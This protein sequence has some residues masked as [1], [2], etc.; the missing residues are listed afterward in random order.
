MRYNDP[1]MQECT[2]EIITEAAKKANLDNHIMSCSE[3]PAF[4]LS[5]K[6][7]GNSFMASSW[8]LYPTQHNWH[9]NIM[10]YKELTSRYLNHGDFKSIPGMYINTENMSSQELLDSL[11]EYV[12]EIGFPC[13]I[14]PN[15]G[16]GSK[17]IN[18]IKDKEEL[19]SSLPHIKGVIHDLLIQKH[20]KQDEYRVF[21][22]KGEILYLYK[23]EFKIL[24]LSN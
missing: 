17:N 12:Q 2:P 24:Q 6:E 13:V 22:H 4:L 11:M 20:I 8:S 3:D 16:S 21:I 1:N 19:T 7:T 9:A 15:T 18:I 10:R 23:K 14:K 5:N